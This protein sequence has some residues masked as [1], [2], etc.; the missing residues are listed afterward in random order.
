MYVETCTHH[1][2]ET[3][4]WPDCVHATLVICNWCRGK[5]RVCACVCVV[6]T[7]S[8]SVYPF[9][10][11]VYAPLVAC[12]TRNDEYLSL[13]LS[14]F[15]CLLYM[16]LFSL[17]ALERITFCK[18]VFVIHVHVWAY[19]CIMYM[20]VWVHTY[21][22]VHTYIHT[23]LHTYLHTYINTQILTHTWVL[24]SMCMREY[25]CASQH[26]CMYIH[27]HTHTHTHIY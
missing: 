14:L 15:T 23:Y 19:T 4:Q 22:Y 3:A 2:W 5:W 25:M 16:H 6:Y 8:S 10:W 1:S 21:W 17:V 9:F 26:A 13:S 12:S 18:F 20:C 24:A 11:Y 7:S 27:I